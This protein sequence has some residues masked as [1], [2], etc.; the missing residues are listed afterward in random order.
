MGF[1][2]SVSATQ[3]FQLN[4]FISVFFLQ[5]PEQMHFS[6]PPHFSLSLSLLLFFF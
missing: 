5:V 1:F 4:P 3:Y 6:L 2:F